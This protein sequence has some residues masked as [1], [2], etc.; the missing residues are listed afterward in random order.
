M[1]DA[2][3]NATLP[4]RLALANKGFAAVRE[5]PHL[6]TGLNVYRGPLTYKAVA[7]SLGLPFSPIEQAAA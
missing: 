1:T 4:L 3:N 2:L 7:E 5:D 6:R